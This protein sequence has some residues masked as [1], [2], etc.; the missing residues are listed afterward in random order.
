MGLF[1]TYRIAGGEGG[2]TH[3]RRTIRTGAKVALD[4]IDGCAGTHA[5][6]CRKDRGSIPTNNPAP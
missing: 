1:E 5:P 4:Q 2:M 3:F 6:A